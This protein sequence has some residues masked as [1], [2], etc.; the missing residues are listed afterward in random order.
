MRPLSPF[1]KANTSQTCKTGRKSHPKSIKAP[2]TPLLIGDW[3]DFTVFQI[4]FQSQ[5]ALNGQK[6]LK[7]ALHL[8]S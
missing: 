5:D 1:H 3:G 7:W 8:P 6:V 4:F 2:R